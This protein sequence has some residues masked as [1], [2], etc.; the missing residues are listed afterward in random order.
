MEN[1]E[2]NY[3]IITASKD[4]V[5]K[6]LEGGFAQAGHGKSSPLK[7][8][9]RGDSVIFY[10]SKE[11]FDKKDKCQEFTAIGKVKSN[12]IYQVEMTPGFCPFRIDID[13]FESKDVPIRPLINELDFIPNKQKWGYPFRW[14][15]IQINQH[16]FE[17]ISN[18]MLHGQES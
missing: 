2:V 10:S 1:K 6:G 4:H 18:K 8:M 9:K 5:E 15:T 7:K 16:D 17:L 12:D 13:F 11:Y 14:G 3:W